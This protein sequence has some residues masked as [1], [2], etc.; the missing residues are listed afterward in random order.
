MV[1]LS[2][3]YGGEGSWYYKEAGA[4]ELS[5]IVL[6]VHNAVIQSFFMGFLFMISGYFTPGSYDRKGP[7]RFFTDRLLRLGIPLLCYD[8]IIGPLIVHPLVRFGSQNPSGS[9]LDFLGRYYTSFH[10]GTGPLWFV[11]TLLIFAGFYVLWRRWMKASVRIAQTD[12]RLPGKL[13]IAAF[14][15]ALGTVTFV[16]R[17]WLPIGW[18]FGP[19]N[20]QFPFFCQYVALFAVG[21][22]AYRRNWFVRIDDTTGRFWLC[23]AI[24]FLV[25]L[26]PALFILGGAP[27]DIPL[28]LG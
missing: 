4:D 10:I 27:E 1:H 9:Y 21:I 2:I 24:I 25:V 3:T 22:V 11:E 16:V 7:R 17:I 6:T 26:L 20:L 15:L 12:G 14:S 19:L 18:A 8:F 23:A 13:E 5:A 28:F